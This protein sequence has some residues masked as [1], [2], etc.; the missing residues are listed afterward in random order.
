MKS[1]RERQ[2][3]CRKRRFDRGL[4]PLACWIKSGTH[5]T[6][7][8]IAKQHGRTVAE[9]IELGTLLARERL[10]APAKR[11]VMIAATAPTRAPQQA[12]IPPAPT[13]T[14]PEPS[15]P[16]EGPDSPPE[17]TPDVDARIHAAAYRVET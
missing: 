6:L 9:V 3:D 7:R 8:G 2:A 4:V 15:K 5:A 13:N 12:V 10:D 16:S 14:P 11:R 1:N 17:P